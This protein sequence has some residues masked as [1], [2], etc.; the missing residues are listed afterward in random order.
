[1]GVK[2]KEKI[3][4]PVCLVEDQLNYFPFREL[5]AS[6]FLSFCRYFS[7]YCRRFPFLSF[8]SIILEFRVRFAALLPEAAA[9]QVIAQ[10]EGSLSQD[11]YHFQKNVALTQTSLKRSIAV[12]CSK[13]CVFETI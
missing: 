13:C 3:Q 2:V 6:C 9:I 12:Y 1:M 5:L 10:R 8:S 7:I 11:V 4:V